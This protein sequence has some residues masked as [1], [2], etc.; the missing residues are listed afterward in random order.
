MRL[1]ANTLNRKSL[2]QAFKSSHVLECDVFVFYNQ[3]Y[4]CFCA[5]HECEWFLRIFCNL[6]L[7][8]HEYR[9][10]IHNKV[11]SKIRATAAAVLIRPLNNKYACFIHLCCYKSIVHSFKIQNRRFSRKNSNKF[12]V[13]PIEVL[14]LMYFFYVVYIIVFV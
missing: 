5:L 1:R 3:T 10:E 7:H 11:K 2:F 4:I 8:P 14:L 9:A 12:I 13:N 6:W